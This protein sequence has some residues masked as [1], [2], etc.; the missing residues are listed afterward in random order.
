VTTTL[1]DNATQTSGS[2]VISGTSNADIYQ[3]IVA[4]L[5]FMS[6]VEFH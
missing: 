6:G 1:L 4:N 3:L 5:R 2:I